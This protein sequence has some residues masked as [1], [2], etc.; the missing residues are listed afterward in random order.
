MRLASLLTVPDVLNAALLYYGKASNAPRV[1]LRSLAM[2][3]P[4]LHQ[5]I[6]AR[7]PEK[8]EI[9]GNH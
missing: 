7:F 2:V 6:G 9:A 1:V 5:A 3:K 8:M 4:D